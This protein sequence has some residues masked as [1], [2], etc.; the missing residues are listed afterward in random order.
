MSGGYVHT[1]LGPSQHLIQ[2]GFNYL[3]KHGWIDR[4]TRAVFLTFGLYSADSNL[5]VYCSLV[6][7]QLPTTYELVVRASFQ[8]L[9]LVHLY[10]GSDLIYCLIYIIMIFYYMYVEVKTM[11]ELR[12]K[13]IK[14]FWSYMNWAIVFC[15]WFGIV[16]HVLREN[17]IRKMSN[18]LKTASRNIDRNVSLQFFSYLD[19]VL[20]YLLGFCCFFGTIKM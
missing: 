20:T 14:H 16:I 12:R 2:S 8:P 17:E 6:V 5:F 19:S 1:I 10:T 4:Y 15:S 9:R 13:Y 11:F 3:R 7:E 18:G